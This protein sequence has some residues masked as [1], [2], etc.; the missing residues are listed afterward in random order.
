MIA[1]GPT[2]ESA[3]REHGV[4]VSATAEKPSPAGLVQAVKILQHSPK[5]NQN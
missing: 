4:G 5:M 1:I 3:L 2:T